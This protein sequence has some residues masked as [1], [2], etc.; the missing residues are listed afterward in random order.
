VEINYSATGSGSGIKQFSD[1]VVDFAGSDIPLSEEDK[2]NLEN[3][4][5]M[6]PTAGGAVAV[7]YNLP[8][9]AQ[10]NLSRE[11][12]PAIFLGEIKTGMIRWLRLLILMWTCLI[13]QLQ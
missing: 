12:L 6:V 11:A 13:Y 10:L 8:E 1:G 7:I 9:V 5:I 4:L 3:G 2:S